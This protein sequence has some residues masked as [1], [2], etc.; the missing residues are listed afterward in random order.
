MKIKLKDIEYVGRCNALSYVFFKKLFK[1]NIL[2]ELNKM[3]ECLFDINK[4]KDLVKNSNEVDEILTRL[5]YTL[6]YTEN[7]DIISFLKFKEE[8][9]KIQIPIETMNDIISIFLDSFV[10]EELIEAM[11]KIP[12][13]D[14]SKATFLEHEFLYT[15][16]KNGISIE[17][18]KE[19]TYVDV[20]KILITSVNLNNENEK[21]TY[22][23]ATQQ[24]WDR[25]AGGM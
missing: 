8:L 2:D 1:K 15:C 3:R 9:E 6:I 18:L 12:N 10:D 5:M 24:D 17:A 21:V 22:R 7:K 23:K 19:L 11:K 20:M 16:F 4:N 13:K 25:F 14:N